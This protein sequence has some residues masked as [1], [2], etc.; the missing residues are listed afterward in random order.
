MVKT[1]TPL[2]G[3]AGFFLECFEVHMDKLQK[4]RKQV[5]AMGLLAEAVPPKLE[6]PPMNEE[7]RVQAMRQ[8]RLDSVLNFSLEDLLEIVA[9][10]SKTDRQ[11]RAG[12]RLIEFRS[13]PDKP[14]RLGKLSD[15]Q[16]YEIVHLQRL[17]VGKLIKAIEIVSKH[18]G[19]KPETV[20]RKYEREVSRIKKARFAKEADK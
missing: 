1:G 6:G 8:Y 13:K 17:S 12:V 2:P 18:F 5:A 10:R 14:G 20:K 19:M 7:Q 3:C 4:Y 9:R 11:F 16:L 15:G